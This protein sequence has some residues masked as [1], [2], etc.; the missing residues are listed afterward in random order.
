MMTIQEPQVLPSRDVR[1]QI[2]GSGTWCSSL[3]LRTCYSLPGL[4]FVG[5]SLELSFW[6]LFRWSPSCLLL[7]SQLQVSFPHTAV[8]GRGTP[9][10]HPFK[11]T[12][13]KGGD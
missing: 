5:P 8:M 4:R 7:A 9:R 10:G 1:A 11:R 13:M 3:P 12:K 2:S 6:G